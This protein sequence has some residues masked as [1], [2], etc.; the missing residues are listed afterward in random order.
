VGI[1]YDFPTTSMQQA[2]LYHTAL[3]SERRSFVETFTW[4]VDDR[5]IT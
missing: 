1:Q 5:Y 3:D 2:M 4:T